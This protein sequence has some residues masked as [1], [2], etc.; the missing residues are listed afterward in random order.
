M[1]WRRKISVQTDVMEINHF[2]ETFKSKETI[3]SIET[4][5]L[6]TYIFVHYINN[7]NLS[8]ES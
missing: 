8:H 5:Y 6:F 4:T 1:N 7:L 2:V 3:V